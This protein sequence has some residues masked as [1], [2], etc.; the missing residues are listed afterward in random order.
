[1][2]LS[3]LS[4]LVT[5]CGSSIATSTPLDSNAI[6][7]SLVGTLVAGLFQTRTALAPR[8]TL[9]NTASPPPLILPKMPTAISPTSTYLYLAP[10]IGTS[11][12]TFTPSATGTIFRPTVDPNSLAF[13][14]NN[15]AFVR[16]VT[17]PAGTK[18]KPGE[19]FGKTWKVANTG[20]CDWLNQ[21]A[22]VLVGGD[23]MS[24][25]TTKLARVVTKGHWT[26]LTVGMGAP[27]SPGTY[28]AYWRLS[29]ADGNMFGSSLGS[30]YC[31]GWARSHRH[32]CPS[33]AHAG[34]HRRPFR[35]FQS[36]ASSYCDA[37][38]VICLCAVR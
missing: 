10:T 12:P 4:L 33:H 22:L 18:L 23:A 3:L 34:S 38:S 16:D 7:T 28:T 20:T 24:G 2:A 9:Y 21:Y 26:E 1:M 5:A 19:D 35:Y 37:Y 15:L 36:H 8:P 11:T 14:C 29:D 17:I 13:G 31:C 6:S 25:K 30:V 32:P 27:K